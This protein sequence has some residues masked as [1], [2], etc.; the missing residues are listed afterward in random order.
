M[1]FTHN[2][3]CKSQLWVY[4]RRERPIYYASRQMSPAERNYTTTE[5]EALG[6]M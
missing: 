5:R 2:I 6:V 1:T 3:K 4:N